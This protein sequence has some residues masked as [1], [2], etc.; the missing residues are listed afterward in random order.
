MSD[1]G[2]GARK[3]Y[4]GL[5]QKTRASGWLASE[6]PAMATAAYGEWIKSGPKTPAGK[7]GFVVLKGSRLIQIYVSDSG[8][9]ADLASRRETLDRLRPIAKRAGPRSDSLAD[10]DTPC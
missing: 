4:D 1:E 6:E 2:P 5:K 7:C 10:D 8:G 9:K 3:V